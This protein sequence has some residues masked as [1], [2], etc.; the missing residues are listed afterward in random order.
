MLSQDVQISELCFY[1]SMD[2]IN[3]AIQG[4]NDLEQMMHNVL[5]EVLSIFSCDRAWLVYPCDPDTVTWSV[6]MERTRPEYPGAFAIGIE[7]PTDL[8]TVQVFRS[9]LSSSTPV[10]F[11][12]K[13]ESQIPASIADGFAVQ[14]QIASTLYP[15]VGKPWVFGIHQCAYARIWSPEEERL[16]DEIGHRLCDSL[17]SLLIFQNLCKSEVENRAII[18]AVPDLL[19][20]IAKDGVITDY[21]KPENME[22][23]VPPNKFL[24]KTYYDILPPEVSRLASE[25]IDRAHNVNEVV[26]FE[27]DL[28]MKGQRCYYEAR[29]IALST[30][31]VLAVVRDITDRR[32]S[33][34][35]LQKRFDELQRWSDVTLNREER[36]LDLKQEVNELLL[37]IKEPPKYQSQ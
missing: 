7:I 4:V 33:E 25:A 37:R 17:T 12:Q 28:I 18:N 36:I 23:Y 9:L 1:E 29:I 19:F 2:R 24:Y 15:K 3:R 30:E 31:E 13:L 6:P 26:T 8:E 34:I 5:D 22:L 21:R 14:S 11:S 16:F 32:R 27:Y 35:E 20:R 10:K